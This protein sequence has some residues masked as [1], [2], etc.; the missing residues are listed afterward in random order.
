MK[1]A[2][3]TDGG[4]ALAEVE[5]GELR[6]GWARLRVAACG[7][8]GTDLH[9]LHASRMRVPGIRPGHEI[10][11]YP[12]DGPAGLDDA[13]YAVEPRSWCGECDFCG[14]GQRHLCPRGLLLG[15]TAHGGLGESVDAPI[16]GLHRVP[17]SLP[18]R[19]ASLAEPLAVCVRGVHL[20]EIEADS[21]VLVLGG[22]S[23][24]LLS[25]LLAR[26]RADRVG[27]SVRHPQQELAAT[28]LGLEAV[29]E[30]DAELWA[31]EVAPDVVI[32]TVGGQA[33]TADL[34]VRVCRPGGRVI[35]IGVFGGARPVDL[36][37][38]MAKEVRVI[39]SNTYGSTRRG[40]EFASAVGLLEPLASELEPL[41]THHF[42]LD[43]VADAFTCAADKQSGAIKVTIEL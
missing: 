10:V 17:S 6:P 32:E 20:A 2:Q 9:L 24:G 11:G 28:A 30:A 41:Q 4:V 25:G 26:D 42:P 43:K 39:G 21:R 8:C 22:G 36:L 40:S 38:L 33:D 16:P 12:I 35:V 5:P 18:S 23:I 7:I 37:Q 14:R 29:S 15:L 1:Q 27:I 19:V 34:A 31:A 3:W 13:L